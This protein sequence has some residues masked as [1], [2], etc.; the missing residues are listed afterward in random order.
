MML[1]N[2]RTILHLSCLSCS[3]LLATGCAQRPIL[4]STP[5]T[6]SGAG[7]VYA[8]PK[9]QFQLDVVRKVVTK[10]D[11]S[12]A[13]KTLKSAQEN[14]TKATSTQAEAEVTLSQ[15]QSNVGAL[16]DSTPISVREKLESERA[17]ATVMLRARVSELEA[18]KKLEAEAQKRLEQARNNLGK[19][20]QT[21]SLKALPTIADSSYRYQI[22]SL[23]NRW[24]DDAIKLSVNNGLLSAGNSETTGQISSTVVNI[25]SAISGIQSGGLQTVWNK[26]NTT[27]CEA[28]AISQVFDPTDSEDIA[29]VN[30]GLAKSGLVLTAKIAGANKPLDAPQQTNVYGLAYRAPASVTASVTNLENAPS[31]CDLPM[32]ANAGLTA[33]APDS[34]TLFHLPVTGSLL[35]KSKVDLTFKDGMP[36]SYNW[37]QP[38]TAAALSR[39]PI[40]IMKAIVE[41]P[42]SLLRV[43]VDYDN[44]AVALTEAQTKQLKAQLDLLTAKQKLQDAKNTVPD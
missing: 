37:D 23:P 16:A 44:Q 41:V 35:T 27:K 40:D 43:R 21:V 28:V 25:I 33:T 31:V 42:A 34:R 14:T 18:A 4:Q 1:I 19:T 17:L 12:T 13:E 30:T 38:S 22:N 39:L 3:V 10:A 5:A 9:G 32:P 15:A 8:L 11:V 7:L 2:T 6:S 36:S 24:R 20:E 26:A 29:R